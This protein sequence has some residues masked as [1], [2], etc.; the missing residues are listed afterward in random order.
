M[1]GWLQAR[2]TAIIAGIHA[3]GMEALDT[4]TVYGRRDGFKA[5]LKDW[6]KKHDLSMPEKW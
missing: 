2:D 1:K 4:I 3:D 6:L 5:G